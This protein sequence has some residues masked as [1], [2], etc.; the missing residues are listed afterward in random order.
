MHADGVEVELLDQRFAAWEGKVCERED[1]R[2]GKS[3][4]DVD[5]GLDHKG[6]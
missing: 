1:G 4:D 3:H 2:T 6:S 5:A